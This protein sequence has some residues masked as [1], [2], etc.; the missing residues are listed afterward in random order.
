MQSSGVRGRTP[1]K[2]K[3]EDGSKERSNSVGDDEVGEGEA[4]NA[5]ED[6][7]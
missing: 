4:L 3:T 6:N 1:K 7:Q 2:I 5:A